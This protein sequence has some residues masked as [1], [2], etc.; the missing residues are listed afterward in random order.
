MDH[1]IDKTMRKRNK[2]FIIIVAIVIILSNTPPIQYFFQ[3][4]YHY[5]NLDGSYEFTEQSGPTQSY[6]VAIRKFESFKTDNP[7]NPNKTLYR[8]F[9]IKPWRFWEWWQFLAHS[10]R[11]TLPYYLKDR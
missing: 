1:V 8:T 7:L 11:F 3:E 2:I 9:K 10:K 6:D 5:K 4:N